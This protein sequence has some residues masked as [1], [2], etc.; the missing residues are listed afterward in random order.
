MNLLFVKSAECSEVLQLMD[1]DFS[2][3][4]ALKKVLESNEAIN[5]ENLEKELE[6]YI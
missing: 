3:G 2:Y 5:K 4:V 1:Q 6:N